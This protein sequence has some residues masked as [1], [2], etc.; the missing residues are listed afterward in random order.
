MKVIIFVTF[1][2]LGAC[3]THPPRI[4]TSEGTTALG[5][6][7]TFDTP[8]QVELDYDFTIEMRAPDNTPREDYE[9]AIHTIME[10]E[11]GGTGYSA[12]YNA[13]ITRDVHSTVAQWGIGIVSKGTCIMG[14]GKTVRR[15]ALMRDPAS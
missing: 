5:T 10:K 8:Q 9:D 7:K 12:E 2:T 6:Y 11:C 13:N 14:G 1:L 15:S 4:P 3:T